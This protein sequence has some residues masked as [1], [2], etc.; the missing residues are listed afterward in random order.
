MAPPR[1]LIPP[2]VRS[3][4]FEPSD[5]MKLEV[6]AHNLGEPD[7]SAAIRRLIR[8]AFAGGTARVV[9]PEPVKPVQKAPRAVIGHPKPGAKKR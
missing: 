3:I 8:D 9:A 4:R 1:R 7:G 5:V 6:V 2:V